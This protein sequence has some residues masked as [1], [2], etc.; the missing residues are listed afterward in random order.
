MKRAYRND[1]IAI[2]SDWITRGFISSF[3][4]KP[5]LCSVDLAQL[6]SVL[7]KYREA[8]GAFGLLQGRSAASGPSRRKEVDAA[9]KKLK[10]LVRE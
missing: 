7:D 3:T 5:L 4:H 10:E 1:S 8:N 6:R 2:S 9:L